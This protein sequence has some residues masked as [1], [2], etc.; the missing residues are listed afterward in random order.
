MIRTVVIFLFLM[1]NF[2]LSAGVVFCQ[3]K[4]RTLVG[5]K[6]VVVAGSTP[7]KFQLDLKAG[8]EY[9]IS[10]WFWLW[11]QKY[12]PGVVLPVFSSRSAVKNPKDPKAD[13]ALPFIANNLNPSMLFNGFMAEK[14]FFSVSR[15]VYNNYADGFWSIADVRYHEWLHITFIILSSSFHVYINGEHQG[16]GFVSGHVDVEPFDFNNT[17]FYVGGAEHGRSASAMFQD[18]HIFSGRS[19]LQNTRIYMNMRPPPKS[20]ML[21]KLLREYGLYSLEGFTPLDYIGG[22]YGEIEWGLCPIMVCG[23][24]CIDESFFFTTTTTDAK[25]E[26][27]ITYGIVDEESILNGL[28]DVAYEEYIRI[29]DHLDNAPNIVKDPPPFTLKDPTDRIVL[30]SLAMRLKDIVLKQLDILELDPYGDDAYL[31]FYVDE[32]LVGADQLFMEDLEKLSDSELEAVNMWVESSIAGYEMN[33]DEYL[34]I[35]QSS[36]V[37]LQGDVAEI[38]NSGDDEF[39]V[40]NDGSINVAIKDTSPL[41][42]S[43]RASTP[44]KNSKSILPRRPQW[45]SRF[46]GKKMV[47]LDSEEAPKIFSFKDLIKKRSPVYKFLQT[48][49]GHLFTATE[50]SSSNVEYGTEEYLGLENGNIDYYEIY[51]SLHPEIDESVI[52]VQELYDSA[53][54]WLHG[55]HLEFSSHAAMGLEQW[56]Q[57]SH[58][59]SEAALFFAHW[60]A[61]DNQLENKHRSQKISDFLFV[62]PIAQPI[63]LALGFRAGFESHNLTEWT[64]LYCEVGTVKRPEDVT[65]H[66]TGYLRHLMGYEYSTTETDTSLNYALGGVSLHEILFGATKNANRLDISTADDACQASLAYYFPVAK[67]TVK[68]FG[69]IETGVGKPEELRLANGLSPLELYEGDDALL[70]EVNFVEANNGNVEAQIW[71]VKIMNRSIVLDTFI[72]RYFRQCDIFGAMAAFSRTWQQLVD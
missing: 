39:E 72:F 61:F 58:E 15:D 21:N 10:S 67:Y 70:H 64:Y 60:L 7:P 63:H 54:L 66:N 59:A 19:S 22:Y 35:V 31:D 23:K 6:P 28:N 65:N 5:A 3:D 47:V 18:F 1:T 40:K 55:R 56:V 20:R 43:G 52:K 11:K 34:D 26:D 12:P 29:A 46:L 2:V 14:Y 33:I 57:S 25:Q 49:F 45:K 71:M 13:Q 38:V 8:C 36:D 48:T 37:D 53:L 51:K 69:K 68:Y 16:M 30:K 32:E 24:T 42:V 17:V 44:R 62:D 27:P 9:T 41:L 4:N 50:S